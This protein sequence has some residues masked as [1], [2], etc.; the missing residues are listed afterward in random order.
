[1]GRGDWAGPRPLAARSVER[2]RHARRLHAGLV[3]G[4][5]PA[6]RPG[7][8]LRREAVRDGGLEAGSG[9]GVWRRRLCHRL[10]CPIRSGA[11][12]RGLSGAPLARRVRL[13]PLGQRSYIGISGSRT[14]RAAFAWPR[15]RQWGRL[16]SMPASIA[17]T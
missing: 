1:V 2:A 4:A 16:P 8:R 15:P 17:K 3:A 6:R 13:R 5:R 14:R 7:A 10:L 9:R 11:R 12:R